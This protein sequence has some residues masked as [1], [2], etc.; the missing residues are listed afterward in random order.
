MNLA[1]DFGNTRIKAACFEGTDMLSEA[2]FRNSTELM[3][4]ELLK[5][6]YKACI[7]ASVTKEHKKAM[8]FMS[9][10]CQTLLFGM[11][12]KLP[13]KNLYATPNT[14][15][16]DRLLSS[17]GAFTLYPDSNVLTIDAGTCLKYNFVNASNE[18][19]GGAISP[20]I[21]MR[22][23]AMHQFTDALPLLEP[24]ENYN[25]LIGDT[26]T[27][28]LLSGAM[29]GAASEADAMIERYKN[30]YPGIKVVLTGGDTAYLSGLLKN[31]FF[32]H[33]NLPLIG[34]NTVLIHASKT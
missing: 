12:T 21:S 26:T 22:L 29:I 19:L 15:G 33:P 9:E 3:H 6:N 10:R 23:R 13:L 27:N 11:E 18:F 4:A 28:S 2:V 34:L 17:I 5:K 1:L 20:G 14:L 24:V 16:A 31:P 8:N 25:Q 32:A 30:R 7:I